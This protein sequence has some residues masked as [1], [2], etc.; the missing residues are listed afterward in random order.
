M[1]DVI[2][3]LRDVSVS[4]GREP[5]FREVTAHVMRG[6]RIAL[7]G[8]NGAGKSTLMQLFEGHTSH[9]SGERWI[10]PGIH[11]G[12]M[13][14]SPQLDMRLSI[15]EA[16]HEALQ[17]KKVEDH[18]RDMVLSELGLTPSMMLSTLS[19]GQLRRVSLAKALLSHPDILLLDEPT[20]HMDLDVI[21]WLESYLHHYDGAIVVI[22][23][24]RM[25]LRRVT[26]KTIWIDRGVVR[27]HHK[28]YADFDHWSVALLEH[29]ERT[30]LNLEKKMIEEG[31]WASSGVKARRK[32]NQR[33]LAEFYKAREK[34][35]QQKARFKETLNK[36]E[37]GEFASQQ[38]SKL[39]VEFKGVSKSFGDKVILDHLSFRL[40]RGERIGIVGKNGTGKSTFLKLLIKEMAPDGGHIRLGKSIDITYFDQGRR[41]ADPKKTLQEILCPEGGTEVK[42]FDRSMHVAAY[43]KKFMFDPRQM[44]DKVATLSGGQK[45]RLLLASALKDPGSFLILDEPTN[46]L[47]MD[48]LDMMG[49]LLWDYPGTLLLVSHDRDFLDRMVHSLFIFR[50]E[51]RVD[52]FWGGYTDYLESIEKENTLE[53]QKEKK[54]QNTKGHEKDKNL[55]DAPKLNQKASSKVKLTYKMQYDYDTIPKEIENLE[56]SI[57]T[58]QEALLKPDLYEQ[59]RE[60]FEALTQELAQLQNQLSEKEERWF[61][62]ENIL[63]S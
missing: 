43:L 48:T 34:L 18:D 37:L 41:G 31:D 55:S 29:E 59:D 51:G 6:D 56:A 25:F 28:G 19:G 7:V 46:D 21:E 54:E 44:H 49:D 11:I 39:V 9:M 24:D 13:E 12:Y 4:F 50:G 32:R 42:L 63:T 1:S 20:N 15:G 62:I 26:N 22:S 23:H 14:Q 30:L 35:R 52:R 60:T 45:N 47:D 58:C 5:L 57:K 61:E 8:R 10:Y 17:D 40:Q 2:L 27:V 3:S 33:R 16:L 53:R 38:S 36:I